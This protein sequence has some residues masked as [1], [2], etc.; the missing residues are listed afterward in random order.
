MSSPWVVT[1]VR[2]VPLVAVVLAALLLAVAVGTASAQE[3]GLDR[4]RTER[5]QLGANLTNIVQE[6]DQLTAAIAETQSKRDRLEVEVSALQAAAAAVRSVLVRQAIRAYTHGD[7]GPFGELLDAVAPEDA[8]ERSR[9]LAGLSLREREIAERAVVARDAFTARRADLDR[10]LAELRDREA[11]AA[12]IRAQLE[13]AF[14]R[15][16]A[17]EAELS[18]RQSR[19]RLLS[20]IGQ[21]GLYACP[22]GRPY[23]FTDTWGAP[24]SGGRRHKGV[25]MFAPYGGNVYAITNGVITRLSNGGL[26]GIGLYI[27]GDDGNLYY[28]AHL[29]TI[30]PGYGPGR[31]VEAG[32]LIAYNGD[33]GNARGG[34]PHVHMEVRPGGGENVDPYPYAAA[35]CF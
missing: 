10:T 6:F 30:M 29:K 32:E 17:T 2:R 28:Y 14:A 20:R 8:I 1:A 18:S 27:K 23:A 15:A 25:D 19:Q 4:A 5:E 9:M 11:H 24:R 7:F 22:M 13:A 31:R 35:A 16:K 21:H 33:T 3:A 34:P 26:G 12:G